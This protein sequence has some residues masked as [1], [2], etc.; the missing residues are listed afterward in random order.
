[1]KIYNARLQTFF[2]M[3]SLGMCCGL[4]HPL[5]CYEYYVRYL[6]MLMQDQKEI[7]SYTA[8]ALDSIAFFY[9]CSSCSV[10]ENTEFNQLTDKELILKMQLWYEELKEL[11]A[12]VPN[13]W[14]RTVDKMITEH[15]R[16]PNADCKV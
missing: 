14:S 9:R 2:N 16:N 6:P 11:K 10:E 7:P 5:D 15:R 1:M 8:K 4:S 3:M 12:P 13:E